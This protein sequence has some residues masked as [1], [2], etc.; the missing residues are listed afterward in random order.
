MFLLKAEARLLSFKSKELEQLKQTIAVIP[1]K[2][3]GGGVQS[4]TSNQVAAEEVKPGSAASSLL[5]NK[6]EKSLR[7]PCVRRHVGGGNDRL[8][9][10]S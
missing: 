4:A 10:P 5:L 8:V 1:P 2:T 3:T 6:S 7:V 9:A